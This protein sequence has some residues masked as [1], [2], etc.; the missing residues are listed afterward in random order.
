[1]LARAAERAARLSPAAR[2]R[3]RLVQAD[4]RQWPIS[5]KVPL[6]IC[7]FNGFQHMYTRGDAH[8]LLVEARNALAPGGRFIFDVLNPELKWLTRDPIKRWAKTRF[9]HPTTGEPLEYTTNQTY[10][11]ISQIA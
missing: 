6:V 10:E 9:R 5:V 11:P 8:A 7:P 2:A 3:I 1:M 4:A